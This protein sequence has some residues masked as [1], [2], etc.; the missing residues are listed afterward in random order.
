MRIFRCFVGV[1]DEYGFRI[2]ELKLF[3]SLYLFEVITPTLASLKLYKF[4]GKKKI[5]TY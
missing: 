3:Y 1:K 2:V 5:L 4:W